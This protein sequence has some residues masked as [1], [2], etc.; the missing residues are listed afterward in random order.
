MYEITNRRR[1][2]TAANGRTIMIPGVSIRHVHRL[3]GRRRSVSN[4]GLRRSGEG[5]N[6]YPDNQ[7]GD[8][9]SRIRGVRLGAGNVG[10]NLYHKT[11]LVLRGLGSGIST[12]RTGNG[13]GANLGDL[14][15]L[16][17][18][19]RKR[20]HS[21]SERRRM[22]SNIRSNIGRHRRSVRRYIRTSLPRFPFGLMVRRAC[23]S[24][25]YLSHQVLPA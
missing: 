13:H 7:H 1:S 6:T 23:A 10:R 11:G 19:R 17:A 4:G 21:S 22:S 14:A 15:R 25:R 24:Q 2:R 9:P 16:R 18:G 5:R 8:T 20:G 3:G 12:Y